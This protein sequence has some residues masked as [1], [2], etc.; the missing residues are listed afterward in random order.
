MH[1][2]QLKV[3]FVAELFE[4]KDWFK[5]LIDLKEFKILK[6]YKVLQSVMYLLEIEREKICEKY[7]NKFFW[8]IAKD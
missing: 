2:K 5:R 7:S 1:F 3:R 6:Y 4:K 8:K